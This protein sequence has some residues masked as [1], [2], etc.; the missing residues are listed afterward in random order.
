M[1]NFDW[2]TAISPRPQP[3]TAENTAEKCKASG[4]SK[5][6]ENVMDALFL[7]W[8]ETAD[9]ETRSIDRGGV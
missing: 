5:R 1:S 8:A 2:T 3:Q 6:H 7:L 9:T 4:L